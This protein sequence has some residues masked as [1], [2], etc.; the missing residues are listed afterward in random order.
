LKI[1]YSTAK[2][3]IRVYRKEK[4]IFK[5]C[6]KQIEENE[7]EDLGKKMSFSSGGINS[8]VVSSINT[9]TVSSV[10]ENDEKS[11]LGIKLKRD[12]KMCNILLSEIYKDVLVNKR[13]LDS[14][15][16]LS[17]IFSQKNF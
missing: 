10:P 5:K 7:Q 17:S 14:L 16:H 6:S 8:A 4:R 3:I 13:I 12:L 1:N 15:V 9:S 2:T 11:T